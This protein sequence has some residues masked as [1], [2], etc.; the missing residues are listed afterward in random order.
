MNVLVQSGGFVSFWSFY[1]KAGTK[2]LV[3]IVVIFDLEKNLWLLCEDV[4]VQGCGAG[5]CNFQFTNMA[6]LKSSFLAC[7]ATNILPLS[8]L[9]QK[10]LMYQ[11]LRFQL[12][13]IP[14]ILKGIRI[15]IP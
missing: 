1:N 12:I 5:A 9:I 14:R 15:E 8:P 6:N 4:L 2:R 10:H 11:N 13:M 3:P 7:T